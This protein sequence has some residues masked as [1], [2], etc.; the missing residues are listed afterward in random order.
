MASP[1][2]PH[3]FDVGLHVCFGFFGL[4]EDLATPPPTIPMGLN[5]EQATPLYSLSQQFLIV[6]LPFRSGLNYIFIWPLESEWVSIRGTFLNRKFWIFSNS[7]C[8]VIARAH[9]FPLSAVFRAEP[10][11][12]WFIPRISNRGI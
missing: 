10:Q 6:R 1:E 3:M 9:S 4:A 8:V 5:E 12:F 2:S 7:R 11:T